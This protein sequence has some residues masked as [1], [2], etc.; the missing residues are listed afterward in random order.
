MCL[1]LVKP[2]GSVADTEDIKKAWMRN[3][4]GASLMWIEKKKKKENWH[5]KRGVMDLASLLAYQELWEREDVILA[6]HLRWASPM[7]GKGEDLCHLFDCSAERKRYLLHNGNL[8]FITPSLDSSDTKVFAE[9]YLAKMNDEEIEV[10]LNRMAV[11]GYGK[12]VIF[13][14][15]GPHIFDAGKGVY[16]KGVYLSN[17][18]H[19]NMA[20]GH[21]GWQNYQQMYAGSYD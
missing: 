7:T 3:S 16:E 12:F 9:S 2:V 8:R 5:M 18:E 10:V 4:D 21:K 19:R 13:R 1:L 14:S 6:L 11:K 17:I 15:D 20:T